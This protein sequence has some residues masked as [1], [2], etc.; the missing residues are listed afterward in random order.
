MNGFICNFLAA[1]CGNK[2]EQLEFLSGKELRI[3][4][5]FWLKAMLGN[6]FSRSMSK[7]W[8][9]AEPDILSVVD[10]GGV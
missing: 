3:I 4:A 8:D 5:F 7:A 1:Y 10:V 6:T 9:T 2:N